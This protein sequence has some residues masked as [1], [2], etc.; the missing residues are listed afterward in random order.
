LYIS[1]FSPAERLSRPSSHRAQNQRFISVLL[2]FY[3][4]KKAFSKQC[5]PTLYLFCGC[6]YTTKYGRSLPL[7]SP[8]MYF[9]FECLKGDLQSN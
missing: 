6:L 5:G 1:S 2:K 8:P 7:T 9:K 3:P 4:R